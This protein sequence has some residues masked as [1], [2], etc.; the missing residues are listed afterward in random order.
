[1]F[2][3]QSSSPASAG[4]RP[5]HVPRHARPCALARALDR[6]MARAGAFLVRAGGRLQGGPAVALLP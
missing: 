2:W 6:G 1:M 4:V 3:L 5:R